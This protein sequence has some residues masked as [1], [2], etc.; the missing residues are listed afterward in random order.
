MPSNEESSPTILIDTPGRD[1]LIAWCRKFLTTRPGI[2]PTASIG[3]LAA[4]I[5]HNPR[6]VERWLAGSSR[7]GWDVAVQIERAI[8]IPLGAWVRKT[9]AVPTPLTGM[10][11][12][13]L[14]AKVITTDEAEQKQT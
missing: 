11:A 14:I 1:S 3:A 4:A 2:D 7:P 6:T 12:R 5:G 9:G 10:T 13:T 8:G